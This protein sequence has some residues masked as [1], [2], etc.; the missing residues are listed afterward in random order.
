MKYYKSHSYNVK[1]E[2]VVYI[3]EEIFF[4]WR[5]PY[6]YSPRIAENE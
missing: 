3:V 2:L 6:H 1:K 4:K 5:Y